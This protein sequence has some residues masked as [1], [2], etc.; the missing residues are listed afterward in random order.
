M[1][2]LESERLLLRPVEKEDLEF[3]LE[4]RWDRAITTHLVHQPLSMR[5]QL[6]WYEDLQKTGELAFCIWLKSAHE[7][8]W[9][10]AGVTGLSK[11]NARH[12]RAVWQSCRVAPANQ[13]KGIA[14]EAC[15]MLFDYAFNT[16]NLQ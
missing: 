16:L 14:F 1:R 15:T 6:A 4:L 8:S 7:G 5:S 9:V 2:V 12:Q 3:L 11:F 13:R 10:R